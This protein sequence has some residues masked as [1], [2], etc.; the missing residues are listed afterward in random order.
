M[1][2]SRCPYRHNVH[3]VLGDIPSA[4]GRHRSRG[5]YE[6]FYG[7]INRAYIL[8]A[9][10][11]AYFLVE[12]ARALVHRTDWYSFQDFQRHMWYT[13]FTPIIWDAMFT[14]LIDNDMLIQL[15]PE[16]GVVLLNHWRSPIRNGQVHRRYRNIVDMVLRQH[17]T[18]YRPQ[19]ENQ[20]VSQYLIPPSDHSVNKPYLCWYIVWAS[21]NNENYVETGLSNTTGQYLSIFWDQNYDSTIIIPMVTTYPVVVLIIMNMWSICSK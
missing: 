10:G 1:S 2:Y 7:S 17:N 12:G 6:A 3:G 15:F 20:N 11:R 4:H 19:L 13:D 21:D 8:V 5:K 16:P 18:V 9:Y 14:L